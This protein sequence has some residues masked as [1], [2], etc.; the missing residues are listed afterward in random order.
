M[1]TKKHKTNRQ[2][3]ASIFFAR[4]CVLCFCF[5]S[6]ANKRPCFVRR[7]EGILVLLC[8][9]AS[10]CNM[11]FCYVSL[12][13]VRAFV[14]FFL[15]SFLSSN[16]THPVVFLCLFF[17]LVCPLLVARCELFVCLF[18]ALLLLCVLCFAFDT[19]SALCFV[20]RCLL[21]RAVLLLVL[22]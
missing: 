1:L 12:F 16:S 21:F 19:Y 22:F 7:Q 9:V 17:L 15:S 10:L 3:T 6:S 5:C 2:H 8:V 13:F 20:Y 4:V 11:L 18:A 14:L